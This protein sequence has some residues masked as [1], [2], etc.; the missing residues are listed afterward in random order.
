A[1]AG[2]FELN[3]MQP[4]IA[5]SL[6]ESIGMITNAMKSLAEKVVKGMKFNRQLLERYAGNALTLVTALVP[7]IGQD[8]ASEVS[9]RAMEEGRDI[10]SVVTEAG[11]LDEA[12][13]RKLLDPRNMVTVNN[14]NKA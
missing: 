6:F 10:I 3:V 12:T 9:K 13:A 7:L 1:S 8:A 5:Y 4:V 14:N 11:L 2:Q